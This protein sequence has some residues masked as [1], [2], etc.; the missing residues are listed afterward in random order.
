[1]STPT[2]QPRQANANNQA[3]GDRQTVARPERGSTLGDKPTDQTKRSRHS[4]VDGVS[5]PP[6]PGPTW[7]TVVGDTQQDRRSVVKAALKRGDMDAAIWASDV[8][9]PNFL[10]NALHH[11]RRND[12]RDAAIWASPLAAPRFA[13]QPTQKAPHNVGT[14]KRPSA[15]SGVLSPAQQRARTEKNRA[16]KFRASLAKTKAWAGVT[17]VL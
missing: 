11:E 1:M 8:S 4:F 9:V 14:A 17:N 15:L 7:W 2:A 13:S 3:I 12:T 10:S 6:S 5:P 16:N